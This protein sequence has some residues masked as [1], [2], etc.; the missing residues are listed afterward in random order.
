MTLVERLN[1]ICEN[2]CLIILEQI[3]GSFLPKW[4]KRRLQNHIREAFEAITRD[5]AAALAAIN[6]AKA[7]AS[8]PDA[9]TRNPPRQTPQCAPRPRRARIMAVL[10]PAPPSTAL[11]QIPCFAHPPPKIQKS[12]RLAA[13]PTHGRFVTI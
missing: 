8:P 4:V 3:A 12:S 10:P 1:H 2:I 5:F 6:A 13:L 7:A 9:D 11:A